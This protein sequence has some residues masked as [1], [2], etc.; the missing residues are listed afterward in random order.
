[1]TPSD[2]KPGETF[3]LFGELPYDLFSGDL[4][5]R[6]GPNVYLDHAPHRVLGS[7]D[8][9]A[10][11]DYVLPGYNLNPG[12]PN[13]CLRCSDSSIRPSGVAPSSQLFASVVALRLRAPIAIRVE[14]QFTLG[15]DSRSI[16]K[17][18][19]YHLTSPWHPRSDACYSAKDI[20]FAAGIARRLLDVVDPDYGRI[21]SAALL[22]SQV[23]T[24]QSR[25]FQ[26]AYLALF[27]ALEGLFAP[28]GNKAKVLAIR[29]AYL[30]SSVQTPGGF[31]VEDWLKNEYRAGRSQLVHGTQDIVPWGGSLRPSTL[32]RF[33]R[34]H[35]IARLCILGFIS[36]SEGQ[37]R[38]I[39]QA[40]G[41]QL[42]SQLQSLAPAS[43]PFMKGQH[44]WCE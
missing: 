8:P 32:K 6:A 9:S 36:L 37:L 18:S 29:A 10:L 14:G 1:M 31:A 39:G 12:L 41:T 19:L 28:K 4:P 22:F 34:L 23:T 24:G 15:Q 27:A 42:Q 44:L 20:R 43:G 21:A 11:A 30:L 3:L 25:S 26:M 38:S 40:S 7:A 33:G 16:E 5:V 35:E 13:W 17:P 2:P